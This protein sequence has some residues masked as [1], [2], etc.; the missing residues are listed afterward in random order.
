MPRHR[1]R[2]HLPMPREADATAT[3]GGLAPA[4]D[5]NYHEDGSEQPRLPASRSVRPR[6]LRAGPAMN[7]VVVVTV[8]SSQGTVIAAA[9]AEP[10]EEPEARCRLGICRVWWSPES[11]AQSSAPRR[12]LFDSHTKLLLF[13]ETLQFITVPCAFVA[14]PRGAVQQP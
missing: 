5:A 9:D 3:T 6:P 11:R 14:P 4:A 2:L 1:K 10:S 8:A 7:Q 13:S 12:L